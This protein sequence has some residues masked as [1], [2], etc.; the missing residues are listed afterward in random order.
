MW[1]SSPRAPGTAARGLSAPGSIARGLS[2]LLLGGL[3]LAVLAGC[4]S[5]EAAAGSGAVRL[6][7]G[8]GTAITE[9]FPSQEGAITHAFADGWTLRFDRYLLV[10][11]AVSLSAPGGGVTAEWRGPAVL[12]L[13][14]AQGPDQV[15]TTLD[16]VSATRQDVAFELV[17]ATADARPASATAA[18]VALL[19]ENGWSFYVEGSAEKAGRTVTFALGFDAAARYSAC[20]NGVDGTRGLAPI[21]NSVVDGYI[22]SHAVHLFWDTLGETEQALRFDALAAVADADD[23]VTAEA[24]KAQDLNNLVDADGQPLLGDDGAP[25]FY[26]DN[27]LLARDEQTLH[28]FIA[29][30][31]RQSFHFNGVGLCRYTRLD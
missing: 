24:L 16:D 20:T 5:D 8:G 18:D 25:L 4:D 15:L 29:E 17:R 13:A 31:V 10:I 14:A 22:Y 11:G 7:A 12:D 9:G 3:G 27:G 30:G 19:A 1:K 6:L 28:G 21:N 26:R 23:H 2:V